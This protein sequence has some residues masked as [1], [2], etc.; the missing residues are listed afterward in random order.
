M[1][2]IVKNFEKIKLMNITSKKKN[3]FMSEEDMTQA[4]NIKKKN[5][6]FEYYNYI[7]KYNS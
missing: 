6:T 2:N 5:T 3:P 1:Y 4:T 7:K